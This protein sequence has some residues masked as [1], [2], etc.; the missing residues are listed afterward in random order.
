MPLGGFSD[1]EPAVVRPAPISAVDARRSSPGGHFV[2]R[3]VPTTTANTPIPQQKEPPLMHQNCTLPVRD[4]RIEAVYRP[5]DLLQPDP[6]T[7]RRHS[8]KHIRQIADINPP[9]RFNQPLLIH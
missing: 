5:I 6:T 2:C 3:S 9:F 8:R 1:A 4:P 7:A